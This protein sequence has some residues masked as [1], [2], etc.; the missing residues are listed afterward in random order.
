MIAQVNSCWAVR[1]FRKELVEFQVDGTHGSAVA[2]LFGCRA[3]PRTATPM[4]V[5]DPDMAYTLDADRDWTEVPDNDEFDNGFKVQWE[6]FIRHVVDDASHGY[7]FLGGAARS[8]LPTAA[9]ASARTG[10]R[11]ELTELT[12]PV[13]PTPVPLQAGPRYAPAVGR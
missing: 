11:F 13:L 5:W 1:V 2:G 9:L 3:Q 12:P 7:D 6:L 4:P 8:S 10:N